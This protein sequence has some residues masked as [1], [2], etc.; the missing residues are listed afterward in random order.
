MTSCRLAWLLPCCTTA[1]LTSWMGPA[2]RLQRE[3][4]CG[5]Q[6]SQTAAQLLL[7]LQFALRLFV[8]QDELVESLKRFAGWILAILQA[9]SN[10]VPAFLLE[11]AT[12]LHDEA[13]LVRFFNTESLGG[14]SFQMSHLATL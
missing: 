7:G 3:A 10:S 1:K 2:H 11:A 14:K 12:A 13:L 4:R 9:D 5:H 6:A 8:L